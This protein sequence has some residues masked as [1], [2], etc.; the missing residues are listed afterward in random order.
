MP[1]ITTAEVKTL[2]RLDD[3]FIRNESLVM[4]SVAYQRLTYKGNVDIKYVS[5]DT[6]NS[7]IRTT[8][9]DTNDYYSTQDDG[10]YEIIR[11]IDTGTIGDT[12]TIYVAY[13]YNDY[14]TIID[15][16]IPLVERD[17]CNYLNN[18]FPD[19]NTSYEFSE[20][21]MSPRG[22]TA[23]YIE[24]GDS[25]FITEGFTSTMDI[26]IEGSYRNAGIYHLTSV[27]SNRL[28]I[29]TDDDL[30]SER[31]TVE[32][33][34]NTLRVRRV[35]WP[36]AIKIYVANIIWQN[37]SRAKNSTIK[38]KSLGPS[39]ITYQSLDSGAYPPSIYK[40]LRKWKNAK[41]K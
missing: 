40:G 29:S 28:L 11:R 39:S 24:D 4:D 20:Y 26:T 15:S 19:K 41:I 21:I 30:T 7:T 13:T 35:K 16:L 33:G 3:T 22:T 10:G 8:Q 23:A 5:P 6:V 37:I 36:D 12:S 1:I 9:Y 32:Y 27:G 31:D 14:D 34:S 18:Y 25:S 2:L 38:S 17:L